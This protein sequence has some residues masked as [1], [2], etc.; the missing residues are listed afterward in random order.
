MATPRKNLELKEC[1]RL[2]TWL[3]LHRI[4]FSHLAQSTYAQQAFG[5]KNWG[6][7]TRNKQLGVR[8]GVPDY[9]IIL[10]A[11]CLLFIE[12]KAAKGVVSW[13]QRDWIKELNDCRGVVAV[14]CYSADEAIDLIKKLRE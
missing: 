3:D 6:I 8:K 7:I 5:Q 13:E 4:K 2:A 14:V 11:R 10:P 12:M 9:I 1:Q